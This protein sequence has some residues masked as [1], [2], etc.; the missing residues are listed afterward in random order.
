MISL[1][2]R[3]AAPRSNRERFR[4]SAASLGAGSEVCFLEVPHQD[5]LVR[6]AV[7][8]AA[9]PEEAF[10]V[11]EAE[12]TE[13]SQVFEPPTEEELAPREPQD[14]P[15]GPSGSSTPVSGRGHG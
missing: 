12:L 15:P 13:W 8:N 14:R 4:R 5:L 6:L 10:H 11:S 7:R 9:L 2:G 3:A 1:F